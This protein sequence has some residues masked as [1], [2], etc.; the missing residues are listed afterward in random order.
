M[1]WESRGC[2]T[3]AYG[4]AKLWELIRLSR[5]GS[6]VVSAAAAKRG[7]RGEEVTQDIQVHSKQ[8]ERTNSCPVDNNQT[9]GSHKLTC[10]ERFV[11]K[12][13]RS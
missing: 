11:L 12:G 7:Q 6:E 3:F 1:N 8:S 2:L 9:L 4:N 13:E 5:V 10:L